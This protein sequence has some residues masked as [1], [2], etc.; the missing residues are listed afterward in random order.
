MKQEA[1]EKEGKEEDTVDEH[2][3]ESNERNLG[4]EAV[5]GEKM[6]EETGEHNELYANYET[7]EEYYGD[8]S[9]YSNDDYYSGYDTGSG[10]DTA[11]WE[12]NGEAGGYYDE[13][14]NWVE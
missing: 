9:G 6:W 8:Y 12:G 1:I 3:S 10:Y 5:N 13:N 7:G 14:N 11:A 2:A 4:D